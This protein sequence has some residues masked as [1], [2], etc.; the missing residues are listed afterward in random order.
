MARPL[1][2][3]IDYFSLDV[4]FLSDLKIRKIMRA[5]G[6]GSISI[7]ISLLSNIYR[8]EGYY[9]QWDNDLA[10]FVADEVGASEGAVD[11]VVKKAVQVEFF[12]KQMFDKEKI[13]TSAGIQRRYKAASA[14]KKDNSI[15][16]E[17]DLL[18]PK[19][20]V[21]DVGNKVKGAD[22]EQSK[23]NESKGNEKK[24]NRRQKFEP[25]HMQLAERLF[26]LIQAKNPE[27]KPPKLEKWADDIRIMCEQDKREP[28]SVRNA[29]D[30]ALHHS[31]WSGVISSPT[32][33]RKSYDKMAMQRIS[34]KEVQKP[35]NRSGR[36]EVLPDWFKRQQEQQQASKEDLSEEE[37]TDLEQQVARIKEDLKR[38]SGQI[39]K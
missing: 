6:N 1:K 38:G 8:D 3:G 31:F 21:S 30:W 15:L 35:R 33:L 28:E 10:F 11:E 2:R 16:P 32:S 27:A 22:N 39:D 25:I 36:E 37:R 24:K 23:G 19:K 20:V 34:E 13:L 5:C 7:M 17:F 18:A 4:N 29:I 9:L 14:K 12:S 26:E